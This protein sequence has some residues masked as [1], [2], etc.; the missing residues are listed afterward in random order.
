MGLGAIK[1]FVN[2]AD[3]IGTSG[4]PT[5]EQF[6][7]IAAAGYEAIVNLALPISDNAIPDEGAIVTGLGMVYFHVPVIFESPT[8][9]DLRLFLN[10]MH[11]LEGRKKWVH[12]AAPARLGV[13]LSLPSH[14]PRPRRRSRALADSGAMG[15]DNVRRLEEFSRARLN[16]RLQISPSQIH[17]R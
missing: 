16:A 2:L 3:D 5:R 12:C 13:L 9:D 14:R 10:V 4:Q 7:E 15:A 1:A 17:Q 6:A 11:A 8:T